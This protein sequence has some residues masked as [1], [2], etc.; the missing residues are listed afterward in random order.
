MSPALQCG[1]IL[2]LGVAALALSLSSGSKDPAPAT[3]RAAAAGPLRLGYQAPWRASRTKTFG[4]AALQA[5]AYTV[6]APQ[7]TASAGELAKSATI[8]AGV[9]PQLTASLGAPASTTQVDVAGQAAESYRWTHAGE[10]ITAVVVGADPDDLAIICS[11]PA[12]LP[13]N[14]CA[15]LEQSAYFVGG[16]LLAPGPS[17]AISAQLRTAADEVT[18]ARDDLRGLQASELSARRARA[19]EIEKAEQRGAAELARVKVLPRNAGALA[20]LVAAIRGE[21]KA[22]G[23]LATV[24]QAR[25]YRA[26]S[27]RILA[28][29]RTLRAAAAAFTQTG[30]LLPRFGVIRVPALPRLGEQR[31]HSNQSAATTTPAGSSGSQ[32][33]ATPPVTQTPPVQSPPPAATKTV[34]PPKPTTKPTS[35]VQAT[36]GTS[37]G[38]A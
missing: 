29:S 34:T 14:S 31:A 9:P 35:T 27:H 28:D 5:P 19:S 33:G 11:V 37:G 22:F 4:T 16:R 25:S 2:L 30:M 13:A 38:T 21:A 15:S 20:R 8:P 1:A 6:R 24:S 7:A 12:G 3:A 18:S 32:V 17:A 36:Q 10:A 26:A 23:A